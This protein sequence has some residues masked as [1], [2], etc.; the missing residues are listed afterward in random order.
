[1]DAAA[2]IPYTRHAIATGVGQPRTVDVWLPPVAGPYSVL[3]MQDGQN[4]FDPAQS[5]SGVTWGVAETVTRLTAQGRIP[6]AMVV[7]IHNVPNRMGEYMPAKAVTRTPESRRLVQKDIDGWRAEVRKTDPDLATWVEPRFTADDYLRFLVHE[8][9]PFIDS[10]YATL[11]APAHTA[12]V[13]SSMG[14]LISAYGFCEYPQVFGRA[15]CLS[16]AWT[17]G[18]GVAVS[19]FAEALPAPQGRRIY[20]D[21]GTEGL[22]ADYEPFQA[23]A[24]AA[25]HAAGYRA[26][27]DCLTR[28]F[29]GHLHHESAWA[30]RLHVP[31]EFLL[32]P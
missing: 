3:Y 12:L 27:V 24:D 22:D 28:K 20:F 19:W 10:T 15:G 7:G 6:P 21:Y 4:L 29:P 8:L 23:R 2:V 26:G 30:E 17:V 31:L 5:Y 1:M 13:G 14:G 9:K 18:N 16:T 11:P 25:L 32:A